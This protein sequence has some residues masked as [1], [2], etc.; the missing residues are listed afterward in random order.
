MAFLRADTAKTMQSR[1]WSTDELTSGLS[2]LLEANT[3]DLPDDLNQLKDRLFLI[4]AIG[5]HHVSLVNVRLQPHNAAG[6]HL[7]VL[8][9]GIDVNFQL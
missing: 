2:K 7:M 3:L 5:E 1:T 8:H 4:R 9:F 6:F